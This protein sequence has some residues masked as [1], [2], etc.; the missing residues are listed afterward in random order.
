MLIKK[1]RMRYTVFLLSLVFFLTSVATGQTIQGDYAI[2]NVQTGLLLRIKDANSKDGTPIVAYYPENW[3]C[4]TWNFKHVD[5]TTYKLQNLFSGKTLQP[6]GTIIS[7]VVLEEQPLS[8][9]ND[10]QLYQFE[11]VGKNIYMIRLKGTELY[12]SSSSEKAIVDSKIILAEKSKSKLEQ[13]T[14]YPQSPT[15]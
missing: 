5:G 11:P 10:K 15:M 9:Q 7:G 14:L 1:L 8:Q 6:N 2:K 4:M 12:I 3:K 13:W